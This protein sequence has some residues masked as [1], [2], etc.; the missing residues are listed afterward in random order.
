MEREVFLSFLSRLVDI[1][2]DAIGKGDTTTM[3]K[4][5]MRALVPVVGSNEQQLEHIITHSLFGKVRDPT[6]GSPTSENI[7]SRRKPSG[8]QQTVVSPPIAG[9]FSVTSFNMLHLRERCSTF[10]NRSSK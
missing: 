6:G 1:V 3:G 7:S 5:A 8:G 9:Y 10:F 2:V 4:W